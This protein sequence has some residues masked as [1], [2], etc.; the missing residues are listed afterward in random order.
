MKK[1]KIT[2]KK[3]EKK[4]IAWKRQKKHDMEKHKKK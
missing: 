4:L 3:R 2:W 1:Q